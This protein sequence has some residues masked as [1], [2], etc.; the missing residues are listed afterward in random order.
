MKFDGFG[1]FRGL[2]GLHSFF[3]TKTSR[4]ISGTENF[5]N[6]SVLFGSGTKTSVVFGTERAFLRNIGKSDYAGARRLV[7]SQNTTVLF[8]T[9]IPPP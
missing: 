1:E 7:I 3:S 2:A 6:S 9:E 4:F 8:G 5:R